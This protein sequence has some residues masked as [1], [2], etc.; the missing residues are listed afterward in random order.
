MSLETLAL[1]C[2]AVILAG[3]IQGS[4]GVGFALIVAPVLGFAPNSC[5]CACSC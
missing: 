5:R 2:A 1:V 4:T 3:F